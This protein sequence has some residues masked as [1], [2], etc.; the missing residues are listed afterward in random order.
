M[1]AFGS[2]GFVVPQTNQN[3]KDR[4]PAVMTASS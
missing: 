3:S 2:D 1:Q 4:A